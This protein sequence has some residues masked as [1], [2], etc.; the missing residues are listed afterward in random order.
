MTFGPMVFADVSAGLKEMHRLLRPGG[1]CAFSSWQ[2]V[3]WYADV[4]EAFATNPDIPVMPSQSQMVAA[5][6][7]AGNTAWHQP[8]WIEE[9][10]RIHGFGDIEVNVVPRKMGMP[11]IDLFFPSVS[12][13]L[14]GVI[15]IWTE[16]Q[17]QNFDV[18]Y[19]VSLLKKHLTE[20]YGDGEVVWDWIAVLSTSRKPA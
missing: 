2:H 3:G 18:P 12:V 19:L 14:G 8:E 15:K 6:S 17:R 20:K 4:Q 1:V 11:S 13:L 5:F 7:P 10:L 16:E 9:Q